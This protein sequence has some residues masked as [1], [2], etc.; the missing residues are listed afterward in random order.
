MNIEK[1][2]KKSE[3]HYA[4]HGAALK[5]KLREVI[6]GEER[7][8][9]DV[10][11]KKGTKES[12]VFDRA[13]DIKTALGLQLFQPFKEGV[14]ILLAISERLVTEN[15]LQKMLLS[16]AFQ[17]SEMRIP[18]ALGYDMRGAMHFADLVKFPHAMYGGA[19]NSGKTVGLRSLIV[20]IAFKQP[21]NR[22]NLII[23]D[24]GASGLNIFKSLPH[25]SCPIVKDEETTVR[26]M[27]SLTDEMERR[28]MLP[29]EE[30]R[31]LPAIVCIVDEYI[32]LINN[33]RSKEKI[34]LTSALSSL[35]RRGRHAKIHILLATQE[36]SKESMQIN[37]NNVNARMAFTCSNV[38]S[39]LSLLGEGGAY[40][41]PGN[42]TMLF[43]SP[44]HPNPLC[45]Q[46]SFISTKDIEKLIL[47]I[48]SAPHDFSNKFFVESSE[49]SLRPTVETEVSEQRLL[50]DDKELA[51]I[52]IWA[53][54]RNSVSALQIIE[55]FRMGNRA[56]TIMNDLC[57][58]GVVG[59]QFANQP[60]TVIPKTVEDLSSELV[61]F[62]ERHGYDQEI[63]SEKFYPTK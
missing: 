10:K 18:L 33:I 59:D 35:L 46:G 24:T 37:L 49:I 21:V 28:V 38:Y 22:V 25:L 5:L 23:I 40:K 32:S 60:R 14:S 61:A 31:L 51:D 48:T 54:G 16:P 15:S 6:A 30:L 36:P 62:L 43:K 29:S 53:L 13:S 27:H 12:L 57:R 17:R 4:S 47:R 50:K 8:I 44:E 55:Q 58:R 41:L 39:S 34:A 2:A 42:G 63:I 26:V 7:L 52:I 3:S 1:I 20:S 56:Y 9:F 45:L 11:L 19:T